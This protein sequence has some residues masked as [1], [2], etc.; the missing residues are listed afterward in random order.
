MCSFG[1]EMVD[2]DLIFNI[3]ILAERQSYKTA[4]KP[5]RDDVCVL[6]KIYILT[7]GIH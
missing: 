7:W 5:S 1:T 2:M 3:W 4:Y 6:H